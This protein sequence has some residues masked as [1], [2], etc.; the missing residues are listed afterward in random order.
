ML[1][2]ATSSEHRLAWFTLCILFVLVS[3]K[4]PR[5]DHADSYTYIHQALAFTK[6][7]ASIAVKTNDAAEKDGKYYVAH[8]PFPALLLT[9]FVAVFGLA[10]KTLVMTPI[11]GA[12]A[13]FFAYR[14]ALKNGVSRD[15]SRWATLGLIFGTAFLLC[16]T[17]PVDT[18]L[19][20]SCAMLF[21]LVALN[22]A[23]GAQRGWLIGIALGFAVLSRQL[24]VLA[25][26]VVWAVLVARR[27]EGRR[28]PGAALAVAA[29][30]IGLAACA[31]FYLWLNKVRFGSPFDLGY[32]Y[33]REGGWYAY[34]N[35]RWG[36]FSWIYV[37]S[38]LIRMFLIG[39]DIQFLPP[40]YMV[41]TM[42]TWGTSL[43]FSCPFIFY[44]VR[45]RIPGPRALNLVAW[46]SIGL[47]CLAVLLYRCTLG[48][49]QINGLRYTLDF[50]PV[51]FIFVA[52]GLDRVWGT[53]WGKIGK[54]LIIYSIALNLVAFIVIP[55][56]KIVLTRLP[57]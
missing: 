25:V 54:Y 9:P 29:S 45:G 5:E 27:K 36:N 23:F 17:F 35:A 7:S 12:L 37:P 15:V 33:I 55:A 22:E 19:A 48:S 56:A 50:M 41:P 6:G 16:L 40:S 14:L 10:T 49:W 20:N 42:G 28:L 24:A 34:R 39:F 51:L 52:L 38:N 31:G 43:T 4:I 53:C 30:A 3:Y 1:D 46:L 44:A 47:G 13:A 32:E 8:P 11:L 26:P 18:Y 21:T 57:H 2:R